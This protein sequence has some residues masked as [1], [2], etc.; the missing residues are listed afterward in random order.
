MVVVEYSPFWKRSVCERIEIAVGYRGVPHCCVVFFR[1]P[2]ESC[3]P[4]SPAVLIP[5]IVKFL[6]TVLVMK[7][8]A[9]PEAVG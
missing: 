4:E 2:N 8:F 5:L 9:P 3:I 1:I 6:P 7:I